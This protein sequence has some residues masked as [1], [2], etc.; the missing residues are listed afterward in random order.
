M[1]LAYSLS[2]QVMIFFGWNA[3]QMLITFYFFVDIATVAGL[4]YLGMYIYIYTCMYMSDQ[5]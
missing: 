1:Y 2:T 3:V 4:N 5:I